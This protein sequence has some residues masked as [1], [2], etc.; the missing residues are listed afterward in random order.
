[1]IARAELRNAFRRLAAAATRDEAD[2]T[3]SRRD[4]EVL[5]LVASQKISGTPPTFP[6]M[7]PEQR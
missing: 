2:V 7:H 6:N 3:V 5:I 1:V 4:L